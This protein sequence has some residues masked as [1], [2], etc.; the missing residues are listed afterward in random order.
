MRAAIAI[1]ARY[2]SDL[3]REASIEDQVRLCREG[4]VQMGGEVA[5]VY[6]DAAISG[7]HLQNR[8]GIQSLLDAARAHPCP[9][10]TVIAE[11]L[12]RLSRDQE[13]IAG[14]FKR[15]AYL[16]IKI[17]TLAEGEIN[18][19]RIGLKG[20][21]NALFLKDLALK[22]RRGLRGR[23]EQGRS[24]GGKGY[25]YRV[26]RELDDKGDPVRGGRRIDETEAQIV[27]RIFT[28]YAAGKSPKAIAKSLNAEGI[29]GSSKKHWSPSTIHGNWQRGTGILNN[30]LYIGR[31][32]W[33]RQRFVKDPET[34]N[35]VGRVNPESEWIVKEVP[36]LRIIDDDLWHA[37]K[38]RQ[39]RTRHAV[40]K[41]DGSVALNNVHRRQ[42]LLSGLLKCGV[43]GSSYTISSKDRYA[44]SGHRS[45]G[46]CNNSLTIKRQVI[47]MRVLTGLKEKL[48]APELVKE[49]IAEFIAE[50]NRIRH[51][52]ALTQSQK[53]R[54]LDGVN[55][56]IANI[57]AA[58]EEGIYSAST[59]DHLIA[60][61]NRK[62]ELAEELARPVVTTVRLHPNLAEVYRNKVARLEETLNAD[63]V[64]SEAAET[65]R[66]LIEEIRLTPDKKTGVLKAELRGELGAI[67]ALCDAHKK[68]RPA[69]GEAGRFSLVAEEG[70]EPPTRGL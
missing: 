69:G 38:Q 25:G 65:L 14:L 40:R 19:L 15:L 60:L 17:H 6:T 36:D 50:T 70:L 48:L 23:I 51:E 28:E 67:L 22:I 5:G 16:D 33:N 45:H 66:G 32:V 7:S 29:L 18:E 35:R 46:T 10:D 41:S 61:E 44:C 8:P 20:T 34:G 52:H 43:C 30:E 9:F 49:F 54:E 26:I 58:L 1:Y 39:Q 68:N 55:N 2:S 56:S 62:A 13:D 47:E 4:V 31:L 64:R 37:A 24:G 57:I 3:Q 12:D 21:M 63:G 27:R 59:K 42:Y 11:S 53:H